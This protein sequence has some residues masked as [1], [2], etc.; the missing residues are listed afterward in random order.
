MESSLL[1]K[2]TEAE[3][4]ALADLFDG[5]TAD[6]WEQ[7]S[8][9]AG[10]RV[11][12][13]AAHVTLASRARPLTFLAGLVRNGGNPNRFIASDARAR[14]SRPTSE[15]TNELRA[16]AA[17]RHHPPGTKEVDPLVDI[18]VHTQDV[19]VPLGIDR[20]MPADA[21][22]AAAE[23]VW[24]MSFPF[25]AKKRTR[26]VR[27]RA[28]D[29]SWEGGEG[30]EVSGPMAAILLVLT[31]RAAGLDRLSGPGVEVLRSRS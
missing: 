12:D 13:V 5:L 22:A 25:H 31:G 16:V 29:G 7:P 24:S 20:A 3:R 15:L 14:S 28:D 17:A 6:Q 9:C 8:L 27:L 18:L 2:H 26:G 23:R 19:A 21:A 4:L 11:R 1:W 30:A 10:W